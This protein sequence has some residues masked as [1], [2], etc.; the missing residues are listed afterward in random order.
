MTWSKVLA[1][2]TFKVI[3]APDGE[4]WGNKTELSWTD[5]K[6]C[7]IHGSFTLGTVL[8]NQDGHRFTVVPADGMKSAHRRMIHK[9][10]PSIKYW[11]DTL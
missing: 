4:F 2:S 10:E 1:E 9:L 7:L 11:R 3:S 5:V 8:E 6:E